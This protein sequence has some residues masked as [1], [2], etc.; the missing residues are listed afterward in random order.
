MCFV[1]FC[2][3]FYNIALNNIYIYLYTHRIDTILWLFF[4]HMSIAYEIDCFMVIGGR[5]ARPTKL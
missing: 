3:L 4:K 5:I 1:D 2:L